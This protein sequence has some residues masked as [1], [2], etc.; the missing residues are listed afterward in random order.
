MSSNARKIPAEVL[1]HPAVLALIDEAAPTG[2]FS[3]DQ[4]RRAS[5]AAGVEPRHLKSLLSHLSGLG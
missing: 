5:D 1:S 3:P 4:V 2:S